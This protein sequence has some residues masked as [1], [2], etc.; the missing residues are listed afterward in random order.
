MLAVALDCWEG[1]L[2]R[3]GRLRRIFEGLHEFF[4]KRLYTGRCRASRQSAAGFWCLGFRVSGSA[5]FP[6]HVLFGARV[7]SSNDPTRDLYNESC[8]TTT[9]SD[10]SIDCS[11]RLHPHGAPG[12]L[13]VHPRRRNPCWLLNSMGRIHCTDLVGT[14]K[15]V[16]RREVG[17]APTPEYITC[18][19]LAF[20][21]QGS[22]LICRC[23]THLS[24]FCRGNVQ[25]LMSPV[26][27]AC[28]LVVL[29]QWTPGV[30]QCTFPQ[31]FSV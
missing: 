12:P 26:M 27:E 15:E 19:V 1:L 30:D 16:R 8:P 22:A 13:C 23:C 18:Q 24:F 10:F 28:I 20:R 29:R 21:A 4:L 3:H 6:E 5:A 31:F 17:K 25:L 2:N 9:V 11:S 14:Q 7:N